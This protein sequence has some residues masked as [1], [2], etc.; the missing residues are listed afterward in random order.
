MT[1]TI[2]TTRMTAAAPA[3]FAVHRPSA[4]DSV[5]KNR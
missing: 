3:D 2:R 4:T 5:G 1:R